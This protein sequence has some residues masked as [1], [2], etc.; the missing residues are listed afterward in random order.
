MHDAEVILNSPFR[1]ITVSPVVP[2]IAYT[3]TTACSFPHNEET[4]HIHPMI[5][6]DISIFSPGILYYF[7][8]YLFSNAYLFHK[9]EFWV[10]NSGYKGG[11]EKILLGYI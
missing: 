9:P 7:F 10:Q 1:S 4:K 8:L 3:L 5:H 6:F 11:Y 2:S